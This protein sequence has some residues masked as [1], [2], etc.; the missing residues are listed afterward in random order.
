MIVVDASV[1]AKWF[2]PEVGS[3]EA[4]QLLSGTDKLIAPDLIRVEVAAAITRR[5]RLGE[6]PGEEAMQ[7]C[8][9]WLKALADGVVALTAQE[10]DLTEAIKLALELKHPLQDCIYLAVAM[11]L[12]ATLI[13]SDPKFIER[14]S[15]LYPLVRALG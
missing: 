13:T 3:E 1:A 9:A 10:D 7:I 4:T 8:N 11:R 15:A 5:V 2:L 14:S 6:L 12:K